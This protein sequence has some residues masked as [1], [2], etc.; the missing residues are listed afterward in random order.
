MKKRYL[1][2]VCCAL[3][4][5]QP[6]AAQ[7]ATI[8]AGST[9]ASAVSGPGAGQ[10]GQDEKGWY[11]RLSGAEY[12]KSQWLELK[13]KW[14]YFDEEG[15]MVTGWH[16]EDGKTYWLSE[17]GSM[18]EGTTIEMNGASYD[19][20]E[21]G[22]CSNALPS[23]VNNLIPEDQKSDIHKAADQV[24]DQ[25][26]AQ[27]TSPAMSQRGK[28]EAIYH[29]MRSNMRYS[30]ASATRDWPTEAYQGLRRRHG[31]CF[32]YYAAAN[33]LLSRCNIPSIQV[34]RSTDADHY[35]NL[36]KVEEGWF[37]FDT[38]PRT[39]GG[40]YCL[41]TDAQMQSFSASH[42]GCFAF[43]SSLYPATP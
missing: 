3:M 38:T 36:V 9:S 5:A 10:W 11:Y 41:W 27:I 26:L 12:A 40:Y 18:A 1:S 30:G 42:G 7:A 16:T 35:W 31:D 22:V 32:T 2:M 34:I 4:L 20:D 24:A 8:T 15:Y 29:W 17:D 13:G 6:L 28:A 33:E 37:H 23:S 43:D 39:V 21:H 14:Y 25:I 19:F